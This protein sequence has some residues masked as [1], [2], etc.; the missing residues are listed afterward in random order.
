MNDTQLLTTAG[1]GRLM[2][3]D[4]RNASAGP[5]KFAV[6]DARWEQPQ[7]APVCLH[8]RRS[9]RGLGCG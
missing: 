8:A 1:D 3:W 7:L 4:L 5:V 2:V 9:I 6:P